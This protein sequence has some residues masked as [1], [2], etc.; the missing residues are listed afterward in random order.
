MNSL[1]YGSGEGNTITHFYEGKKKGSSMKKK[2]K[3]SKGR[4]NGK[5]SK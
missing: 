4:S 1:A 5:S 3:C 2:K